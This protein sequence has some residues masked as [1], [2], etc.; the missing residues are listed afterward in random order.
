[1]STFLPLSAPQAAL[2]HFAPCLLTPTRAAAQGPR[3]RESQAFAPDR[4]C[5]KKDRR[6]VVF[7]LKQHPL[8][9]PSVSACGSPTAGSSAGS[10]GSRPPSSP[11][12]QSCRVSRKSKILWDLHRSAT[13]PAPGAKG[14]PAHPLPKPL[15]GSPGR[16]PTPG[17]NHPD[18]ESFY[19]LS[20][21]VFSRAGLDYSFQQHKVLERLSSQRSIFSALGA[22]FLCTGKRLFSPPSHHA[23]TW[24]VTPG[25]VVAAWPV[26]GQRGAPQSHAARLRASPRL[27]QC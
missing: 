8:G 27:V 21:F 5:C 6:Q 25:T 19:F 23:E 14:A 15:L 12:L 20:I 22:T 2:Q 24:R 16:T 9:K 17:R 18:G 7:W 4:G 11:S 13:E 10:P 1:M 3:P 26:G